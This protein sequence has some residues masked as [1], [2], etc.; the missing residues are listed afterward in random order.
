MIVLEGIPLKE[1]KVAQLKEKVMKLEKKLGLAIIQIGNDKASSIYVKQKE[2][3]AKYLDYNFT[4]IHY[5]ETVKEEEVITQI[6]KLN[7]NENID[8]IILQLP[9]PK[10]FNKEKL[11]NM[12]EPKKDIDGLTKINTMKL[13]Q[14]DS[15]LIP[16]TAKAIFDILEEY[17]ID[18]T[19]KNVTILGRSILVGKPVATMMKNKKAKVSIVNSTTKN[20]SNYTL[21]ADII[22][23]AIGKPEFL[24]GDYI[25]EN[26][27]IID[28]GINR[29][30][31]K[32]VGDVEFNSVSKKA[33][34][35]TP[36]PGGV[37][38]MTTYE[39]MN[40]L[41]LAYRLKKEG[42]KK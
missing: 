38:P 36:V 7:Q 5:M 41:Y 11:I 1:K 16:C 18:V 21:N 42:R 25:K 31:K 37:G 2:K 39:I 27:V 6:K 4:Y 26:T 17:H 30:G 13:E 32:I 12:I 10:H 29:K 22:I 40:N 19:N 35:I 34:Y 15:Y 28:V 23:I 9:L 14:N 24:T 8:G 20:I 3:L 33:S